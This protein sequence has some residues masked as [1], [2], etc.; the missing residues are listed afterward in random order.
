MPT[1]FLV[2]GATLGVMRE[3]FKGFLMLRLL[4][5]IPLLIVIAVLVG[6][7]ALARGA[8]VLGIAILAGVPV[9]VVAALGWAMA[10]RAGERRR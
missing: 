1:R 3:M 4:A 7:S 9:V 6:V 10:R 2:L 5:F 8:D